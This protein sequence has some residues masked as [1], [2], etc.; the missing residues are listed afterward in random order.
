MLTADT[1]KP[2]RSRLAMVVLG[3]Q[4]SQALRYQTEV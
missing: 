1:G 2:I 3:S 4:L